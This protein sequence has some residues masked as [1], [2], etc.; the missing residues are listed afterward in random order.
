M[1]LQTNLRIQVQFRDLL[2]RRRKGE[3]TPDD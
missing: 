3:S 1:Y 2:L